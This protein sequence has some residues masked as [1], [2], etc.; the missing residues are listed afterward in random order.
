MAV[1]PA[2]VVLF[3]LTSLIQCLWMQGSG[4]QV[5]VRFMCSPLKSTSFCLLSVLMSWTRW[6]NPTDLLLFHM[7]AFD[8][9]LAHGLLLKS[10]SALFC[11]EMPFAF[12]AHFWFL[13][14]VHQENPVPVFLQTANETHHLPWRMRPVEWLA[15]VYPCMYPCYLDF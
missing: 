6:I 2:L 8:S 10:S 4:P 5:V 9:T 15:F 1:L 13:S 7:L 3:S 14:A 11:F 12:A